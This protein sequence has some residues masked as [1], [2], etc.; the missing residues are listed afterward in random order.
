[1]KKYFIT[2][3]FVLVSMF[4]YAQMPMTR[5]MFN[6]LTFNNHL[7]HYYTAYKIWSPCICGRW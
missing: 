6:T 7:S 1:M 3:V 5:P 4:S 2:F